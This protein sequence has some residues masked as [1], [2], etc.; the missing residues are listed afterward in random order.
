[1]LL[2]YPFKPCFNQLFIAILEITG[3]KTIID[4]IHPFGF[5]VLHLFKDI[6]LLFCIK[7]KSCEG[8]FK[9]VPLYFFLFAVQG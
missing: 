2:Q 8:S 3:Q 4:Q 5:T 9:V 1:L 7:V 6:F